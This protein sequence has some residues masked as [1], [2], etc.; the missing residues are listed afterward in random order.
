M[1]LE[2]TKSRAESIYSEQQWK[3]HHGHCVACAE[4]ARRRSGAK[5]CLMGVQFLAN[6]MAARREL[7]WNR[8]EDKKPARD[9]QELF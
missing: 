5:C 3:D 2:T 4:V 8:Q 7:A 9:Q 6:L 1:S